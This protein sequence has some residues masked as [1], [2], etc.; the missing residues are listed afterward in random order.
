MH[1]YSQ[2][3]ILVY[4]K[5]FRNEQSLWSVQEGLGML[6]FA[7]MYTFSYTYIYIHIGVKISSNQ[8]AQFRDQKA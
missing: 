8:V 7:D 1:R 6:V 4:L 2:V 5:S 3:Q